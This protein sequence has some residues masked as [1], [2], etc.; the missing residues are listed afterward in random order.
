MPT[1][2]EDACAEKMQD[3]LSARSFAFS[4]QA[5]LQVH[6]ERIIMNTVVL[7]AFLLLFLNL[8]S[9]SLMG[10]DKHCARK[11]QRRITEKVLFLAAA[12]FGGLGGVLGMHLFHHKTRH[13]YFAVFFPFFLIIQVALLILALRAWYMP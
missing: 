5:Y 13:W 2:P 12:C 8:L 9:F 3:H 10:F 7:L 11:R 1:P 6:S 4:P